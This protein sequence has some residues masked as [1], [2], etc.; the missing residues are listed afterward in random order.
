MVP[1][2]LRWP[3]FALDAMA[4]LPAPSGTLHILGVELVGVTSE[5]GRKLLLSLLIIVVVPLLGFLLTKAVAA[6]TG[7]RGLR[8]LGFWARQVINLATG[9]FVVLAL[10]SIWFDDPARLTTAMGLITAGV[11]VALQRVITA[12]GGYVL[13]L[14]GSVFNVGDRIVIGG[15]RGDVVALG[16]LQTTVMEM[17][18][19]HQEQP[20]APAVWVRSR[21]YTGRVVT[22]S[23]AV[24]FDQPVYNYTR[25]F[26]FIFEEMS[27]PIRYEDDYAKAEEILLNAAAKHTVEVRELE[28]EAIKELRR[29]Y[30]LGEE[31]PGPRTYWRLT[32]NWLELTVRFV[33]RDHGIRAVKDAMSREILSE[34]KAA[35]IA[36]ASATFEVVGAPELKL[37]VNPSDEA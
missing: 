30:F 10:A 4:S 36:I 21:Q 14:R 12:I 18:E 24:V 27:L 23:N 20:D 5:N 2:R 17:G 16:F 31:N 11:A 8:R 9:L 7:G 13:I 32:D 29:R 1:S 6:L 37:R 25:D 35:G 3:E 19:A 28:E 33:V 34:L 15:V 22:V 26:P